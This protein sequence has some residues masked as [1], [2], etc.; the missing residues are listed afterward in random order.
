MKGPATFASVILLACVLLLIGGC[1][2]FSPQASFTVSIAAG[3]APLLVNFDASGSTAPFTNIKSYSWDFNDGS[4]ATGI[5]A[6]HT[7]TAPATYTVVLT[8]TDAWGQTD[9]ASRTIVVSSGARSIAYF[10]NQGANAD[11]WVMDSD[12]SDGVRLTTDPTADWDPDWSP[13]GSTLTFEAWRDG[14]AEIYLMNSDGSNQRN[15]TNNEAEDSH[16]DWSPDGSRI[17]FCSNR[18]DPGGNLDIYVMN[19]DGS[20]AV[21]LTN[22][23]SYDWYPAWSPDGS[24]I[25]FGSNRT[26]QFQIYVMHADGTNTV[27]LTQDGENQQPAWSPDGQSVVYFHTG[28]GSRDLYVMAANGSNKHKITAG[29]GEDNR[30]PSWAPGDRILFSSNQ[31]GDFEIYAINPNG[32]GETQLTHNGYDDYH[33]AWRPAQ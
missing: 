18:H 20:G 2:L 10:S 22:D 19:A 17:V 32:T 29:S 11:I 33:P 1:S 5:T 6:T 25:A 15:I 16:P 7:Y 30:D 13:D 12:G 31:T 21:D 23:S 24:K 8:V 14:N 9:T 4:T 26:G 3:D 27:Q 28:G